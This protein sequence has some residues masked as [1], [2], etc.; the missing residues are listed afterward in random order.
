MY[1]FEFP[2]I[3]EDIRDGDFFILI[4]EY[5]TGLLD[6][7]DETG[8]IYPP[9]YLFHWYILFYPFL[10]IPTPINIYIWDVMRIICC[11]Y[12]GKNIS[13]IVEN[14]KVIRIFFILNLFG[15]FFDTYNN[16][17]NFLIMFLLFSSFLYLKRNQR[18][19][20]GIFF[21]IGSYKIHVLFLFLLLLLLTKEIKFKEL[22]YFIIPLLIICLPYF[23]LP[24]LLIQFLENTFAEK[25]VGILPKTGNVIIDFFISLYYVFWQLLQPAHLLY[26]SFFIMIIQI[27]YYKKNLEK[28]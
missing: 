18:W 21:A 16:N 1:F 4:D 15:F 11:Y 12:V 19:L 27:H 7:Y 13:K 10:V 25:T 14:K 2:E 22:I 5:N 28:E 20:A 3:L 9:N 8:K 26:Y 17:N 6:I 24:N 23:I